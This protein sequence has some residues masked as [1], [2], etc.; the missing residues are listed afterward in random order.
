MSWL[1][2]CGHVNQWFRKWC[3]GCGHRK[4]AAVWKIVPRQQSELF[5]VWRSE[6]EDVRIARLDLA[7]TVGYILF[8]SPW[9]LLMIVNSMRP[10]YRYEGGK[11]W[12]EK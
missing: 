1:C 4:G 10:G 12:F 8:L 3:G 5:Y 2:C 7:L 6:E 9:L 11:A